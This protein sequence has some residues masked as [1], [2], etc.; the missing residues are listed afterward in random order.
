MA[1]LWSSLRKVHWNSTKCQ[2]SSGF[3]Y[4][5]SAGCES[6]YRSCK[7]Y[8]RVH[9]WCNHAPTL[10][11]VVLFLPPRCPC[12]FV[13]KVSWNLTFT[14]PHCGHAGG[15]Q[16]DAASWNAGSS[17]LPCPQYVQCQAN[18]RPTQG[19]FVPKVRYIYMLQR[20]ISASVR[21]QLW[22]CSVFQYGTCT[23]EGTGTCSGDH[24]HPPYYEW[25]CSVMCSQ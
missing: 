19:V 17:H 6:L 18:L 24:V 4:S 9:I 2:H 25:L 14:Q 5:V 22:C 11:C 8:Y 16:V 13:R 10:Y 7:H 3:D 15:G 1:T 20:E 21:F 12:W 23:Y